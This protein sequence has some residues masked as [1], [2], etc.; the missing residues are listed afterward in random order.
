M[1]IELLDDEAKIDTWTILYRTPKGDQYN[2]KLTVTNK[3]LIYD[4]KFDMSLSG[5][6]EE[7]LFI[8]FG[9]EAYVVIPRDRIKNIETEKS[10]FAK[11]IILTLDNN[12]RHIFNYGM[13]NI[14]K[15]HQALNS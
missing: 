1:K 5:I 2:G 14:D 7:S 6:V 4:A 15:L 13:L 9:S 11:K 3:R 8:K 12:E 10:F